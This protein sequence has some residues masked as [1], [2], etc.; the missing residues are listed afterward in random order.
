MPT[1][2]GY[3]EEVIE[4]DG[5]LK[6]EEGEITVERK[7]IVSNCHAPGTYKVEKGDVVRRTTHVNYTVI[8][9]KL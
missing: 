5:V 3:G 1:L 6:L 4:E 2:E 9:H 7:G 8:S